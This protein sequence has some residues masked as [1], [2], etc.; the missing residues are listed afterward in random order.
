MK[1]ISILDEENNWEYIVI[2]V[3]DQILSGNNKTFRITSI[4]NSPWSSH[5]GQF[6]GTFYSNK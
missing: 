3:T 1:G 4:V 2:L 5:E 6:W